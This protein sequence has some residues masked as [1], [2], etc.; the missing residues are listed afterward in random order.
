MTFQGGLEHYVIGLIGTDDE[1]FSLVHMTGYD[2]EGMRRTMEQEQVPDGISPGAALAALKE[3]PAT[4]FSDK[5]LARQR[6]E[7][8]E[9]GTRYATGGPVKG[10]PY[11]MFADFTG[12]DKRGRHCCADHGNYFGLEGQCPDCDVAQRNEQFRKLEDSHRVILDGLNS[13]PQIRNLIREVVDG[14]APIRLKPTLVG[15]QPFPPLP[16]VSNEER[17][18]TPYP[19][20]NPKT[21][22]GAKKP[23][24]SVV[25]ASAWLHLA[26]AMM[27]G[28]VKYGPY[29]YRDQP[30]SARTYIAAAMRHLLA[31]LDGEDF[32]ADTVEAGLPVHHLAHVMAC[33][34]ILLDTTECQTLLDNRPTVKGRAGPMV[35]EYA[36]DGRFATPQAA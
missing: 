23:D 31:Y 32:S 20:G 14:G 10:T 25:P 34:A 8:E 21:A 13:D 19:D 35:E 17:V 33:C 22:Q 18:S 7:D 28:S 6:A 15:T 9:N 11:R 36:R 1:G 4:T 24:L 30:V 16:P 27:N 12:A 26:T 29:N 3:E 5:E 2:I